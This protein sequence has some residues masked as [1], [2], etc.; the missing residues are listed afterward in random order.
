MTDTYVLGEAE[1]VLTGRKASRAGPGGKT[2]ELVEV[3][4]ANKDDGT[5]KKWTP[6]ATLFKVQEAPNP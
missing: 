6:M 1:V 5:W 2:T 4:P 3:T